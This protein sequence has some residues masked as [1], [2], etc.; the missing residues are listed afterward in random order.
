MFHSHWKESPR[1]PAPSDF[2]P[3]VVVQISTKNL[4]SVRVCL[5]ANKMIVKLF[6][7]IST[8]NLVS[9]AIKVSDE[10]LVVKYR[11]CKGRQRCIQ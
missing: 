8:W 5:M 6:I 11:I 2:S 7:V 1:V 3:D 9:L 10:T 4:S